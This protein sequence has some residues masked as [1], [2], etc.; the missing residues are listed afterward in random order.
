MKRLH[1]H[2]SVPDLEQSIQFYNQI[3]GTPPSKQKSDY[4]KWQLND[5]VV[6]FAIS[7]RSAKTGLDHLGIQSDSEQ[8]LT[9]LND[10]LQQAG[11]NSGDT[12]STTCCYAES[13]KSWSIDPSGIPW[14]N[15]T[16]MKDAEV[17]A[18]DN[19][20]SA[21]CSGSAPQQNTGSSCC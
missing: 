6:N 14:E 11:I 7:T 3:F 13:A 10:R 17:Y 9:E 4:A 16:T 12:E 5:P 21:C 1:I 8:E 2:I 18:I 20:P 15:F 19:D